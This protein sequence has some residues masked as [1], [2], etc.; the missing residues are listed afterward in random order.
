MCLLTISVKNTRPVVVKLAKKAVFIGNYILNLQKKHT[1][2]N[3]G[4]VGAC[5]CF[6]N[7]SLFSLVARIPITAGPTD[8]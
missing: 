4:A 5:S 2:S 1:P 8:F 7:T 3:L 6:T